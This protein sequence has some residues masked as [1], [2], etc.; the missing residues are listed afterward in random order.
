MSAC[1]EAYVPDYIGDG[2]IE[3]TDAQATETVNTA[4]S[5]CIA[6]T[7]LPPLPHDPEAA[8]AAVKDLLGDLY[9]WTLPR[10]FEEATVDPAF[11]D[12]LAEAEDLLRSGMADEA[13]HRLRRLIAPK[14]ATLAHC[15]S[16]YG[17]AMGEVW[18]PPEP[19]PHLSFPLFQDL[20]P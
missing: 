6:D 17:A 11:F 4:I 9:G 19:P 3:F 14:F 16:A 1:W 5:N 2:D 18:G 10:P 15:I 12:V 7:C 20:T 13:E 8:H